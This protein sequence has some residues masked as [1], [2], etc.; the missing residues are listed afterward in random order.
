M[1]ISPDLPSR[2]P[3]Q[4][5]RGTLFARGSLYILAVILRQAAALTLLTIVV[6]TISGEDF[7]RF[8]LMLSGFALLVPLLSL[9]IHIA[10]SRLYFDSD[11]TQVRAN[12][13]K[14][15]LV[16][17]VGL[18]LMG[19]AVLLILLRVVGSWEPVSAGATRLQLGMALVIL[20]MIVTQYGATFFRIR[21]RAGMFLL[22]AVGQSF[23]VVLGF[24]LI[25]RLTNVGI[26]SLVWA[27]V[28][29]QTASALFVL[30]SSKAVLARGRVTKQAVSQ[31]FHFAWPT[32]VH[33]VALWGISGSGRWIGAYYLPLEGLAAFTLV[34]QLVIVVGGLARA[35]FDTRLPEI[36][37]GFASPDVSRGVNLVTKTTWLAG[38]LVLAAYGG[39]GFL[40]FV[41]AV[42]MP[43]AYAPSLP[44]VL[45]ALLA[46]LWDV[47]YLRGVQI[48]HYS[49]HTRT[50][51]TVT[52]LS[53]SLVVL[54]SFA[55]VRS[56]GDVGLLFAVV[57]GMAL[58][59]LFSNGF[60]RHALRTPQADVVR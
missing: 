26:A 16:G 14:S 58:L 10:P 15:S 45:L 56:Y 29:A 57:G 55:L 47:A 8:G 31:S 36:A 38:A 49:K 42:P 27:Y 23:G 50:Q 43:V 32:T 6:A 39:V 53:G 21:G 30:A 3:A 34:T 41:L 35:V 51:A 46:S 9:N 17:A 4:G 7:T 54:L 12:L 18:G 33:L 1:S 44:L 24:L 40:L 59:A 25:F 60:A 37:S 48:L 11:D 19:V 13:L 52:L 22:L 2:G 28:V 5:P 20:G